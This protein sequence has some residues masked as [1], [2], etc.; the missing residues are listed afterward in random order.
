MGWYE[1]ICKLKHKLLVV[2]LG[3]VKQIIAQSNLK[4]KLSSW[5]MF[6]LPLLYW[7]MG[8]LHIWTAR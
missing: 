2:R 4:K 5:Y 7:D 6:A 1:L 8:H 3:F